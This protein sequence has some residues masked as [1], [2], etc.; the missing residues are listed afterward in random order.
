MFKI[1]ERQYEMEWL[2]AWN[3]ADL[4]NAVK[5]NREKSIKA[6]IIMR[7]RS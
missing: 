4:C 5:L 3:K 1:E 7:I 2:M 6:I